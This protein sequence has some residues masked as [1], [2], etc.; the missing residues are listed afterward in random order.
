MNN[1]K[2]IMMLFMVTA[3][4]WSCEDDDTE[5]TPIVL[6][7]GTLSGGPFSFAVELCDYGC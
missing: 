1:L 6:N 5:I 7:A 3:I 2:T 4:F